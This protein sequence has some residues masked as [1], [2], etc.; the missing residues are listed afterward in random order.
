MDVG[1]DLIWGDDSESE[2]FAQA[3]SRDVCII[4]RYSWNPK[5]PQSL[6]SRIVTCF[7]GLPAEDACPQR[8]PAKLSQT[9]GRCA[10]RYIRRYVA[11]G[12]SAQGTHLLRQRM[13]PLR[14]MRTQNGRINGVSLTRA[15]SGAALYTLAPEANGSWDVKEETTG[16]S[17]PGITDSTEPKLVYEKYTGPYRENL[18]WGR[19]KWNVFPSWR[20]FYPRALDAAEVFSLG[21]TM[22][23]LLEQV[24]QSEV[25]EREQITVSWSDFAED[26]PEDWK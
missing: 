6:P 19:P 15:Q 24:T 23:M 8:M 7:H 26:I 4:F 9:E 22:W 14:S 1:G 16:S 5:F 25:E 13:L 10:K 3:Q 20:D 18:A 11:Y 12:I 21:R 17:S 2:V